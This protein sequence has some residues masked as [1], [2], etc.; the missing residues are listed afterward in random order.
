WTVR[1]VDEVSVRPV[2]KESLEVAASRRM[3]EKSEQ[4]AHDQR[5]ARRHPGA[6]RQ[7]LRG[8]PSERRAER[9]AKERRG[10]DEHAESRP[11]TSAPWKWVV[12]AMNAMDYMFRRDGSRAPHTPPSTR[13]GG[14]AQ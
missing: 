2:G 11:R 5:P 4:S 1:G 9:E 8:S 3:N 10:D 7:L 14:R 13:P 12:D 6:A